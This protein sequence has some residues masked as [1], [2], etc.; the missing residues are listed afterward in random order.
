MDEIN[1]NV[2]DNSE[3]L[4]IIDDSDSEKIPIRAQYGGDTVTLSR[5][6]I[7]IQRETFDEM[8]ELYC[9]H[10]REVGFGVRKNTQRTN[11]LGQV[12]EKYYVC[13][14]EGVKKKGKVGESSNEDQ[15]S[16]RRNNITRTDCKAFLKVKKNDEGMLLVIDHNEE[17]NHELSRKKWSHMHRSHRKIIADKAVVIGD[18]ISS[19]LGPT[20]SYRYMSKEAGG[21]HLIGHTLK[22]HINF[23]NRMRMSAI[24]AG[25]A[26]TLI[27][28]LFQEGVE[29]GDFF[30]RFKL[31][32]DG[33]LSDVFWRDSMMCEDYHLYGDVVVFDT[34]YKTNK[35]G[36]ICAPFVG[37]NHHKKN[38][39]FGCAFI[40]DEKTETFMWLF[41][42][43]KKS[44]KMKCPVTIFTDQDLAITSALSKVF[45]DVRHRLCIWHLYQN[46]ISRFGNLKGNRSF[47]DA[48]QRCLS[49]CVN[50]EEF[51][52]CWTSM[53]NEYGLKDN[54]WFSHLYE[55]REKWC[56]AYNKS[57]F[58]AGILSSQRSESTNSAIGFKASKVTN[59]NEFYT[60]FKQT[61]Q[62]WKSKEEVDEFECSQAIPGS[63]LPLVGMVKH[64]SDVYTLSV[65]RD[66][67][68]EFL[69]SI[70]SIV[71]TVGGE[72]EVRVYDVQNHDERTVHRVNFYS[73]DNYICCT[74]RRFEE[75]GLLCSHCLR[76]LD[77]HS[78]K[79][80]P[81]SYILKRWTKLAKKDLWDKANSAPHT[82]T[83]L[84]HSAAWRDT[85]ARNY[86]TIL[87]GAQANEEAR[88]IVEDRSKSI[89][90]GV[91]AL[92][93]TTNLIEGTDVSSSSMSVLDPAKAKTKGRKKR[94]KGQLEK[95][96]KKKK[97]AE[98]S[99][100]QLSEFG[101]KTPNPRLF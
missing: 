40:S 2:G 63:R 26:Q 46:A 70:S 41:E 31:N 27:D 75:Y 79:E 38:V 95:D 88:R 51:E 98:G 17:H 96:R 43:F 32:S 6:L 80:I 81:G 54:S 23:V 34:T 35:Y 76:I 44:M 78:V 89:L 4:V 22:D 68:D 101:S 36:L 25:D 30:Y 72:L 93:T 47:N 8:Y 94:I 97:S 82:N 49:R 91:Q 3:A 64:A 21:D 20:D 65:F 71:E 12:I 15:I 77:R 39:M 60:I 33:R 5:S 29:D 67:E 61:V 59:L 87:L 14:K 100:T 9:K 11:S 85:M 42:V 83:N 50:V 10:A 52:G 45:P 66:F 69:K 13:S 18:M 37:L 7:G 84:L 74:C 53:I 16:F 1:M 19:R 48:F 90:D 28:R 62:R 56:T 86:Y 58:S 57:Y 24:E 73:G 99:S 55:L 92:T